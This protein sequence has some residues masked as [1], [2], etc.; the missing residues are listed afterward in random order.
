VYPPNATEDGR[1]WFVALNADSNSASNIHNHS[2]PSEWKI[3]PNVVK[4]IEEVAR[5]NASITPKELQKGTG[6]QYRPMQVSLA[7]NNLHRIRAVVKRVRSDVD[8]IDNEKVNP[9]KIIA[10]FPAVKERVDQTNGTEIA[11]IDRLIGKY[12]LD[13]DDAYSFGRDRQY[14]WF[15]APFQADQWSKADVLFVD[16]DHTGCHHFPYLLNVVCKNEFTQHYMACGRVLINRQDGVSIGNA[17]S[18]LECNVKSLY[19]EYKIGEKHKEILL[20]FDDAEANAFMQAFGADIANI[21]RGCSVHF[22]RS[23]MRVAKLVNLPSSAGYHIFVSIAK[24]IPDERSQKTVIDAFDVLCGIKS[25]ELF[26]IYL[27]PNLKSLKACDVDTSRWKDVQGWVDWWR[28]P[29][30]LRKLSSAFSSLS[31]EEWDDL[32][33]TTN[34][35]ES[36]NRQSVPQNTKS[37][38]LKP[39]IEHFYLEDKR[40]AIMQLAALQNVTISY[41]VAKRKRSRRPPKAPESR[42]LLCVVP[43]GKRAIGTRVSVEFYDD[44][45]GNANK[46]ATKWYRGTIIAYSKQGHTVSFDGYGPEHN[47]TIKSLRKSIESGEVKLL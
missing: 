25:F 7:A 22:L 46:Y 24:R 44:D 30:V 12:Q 6:M 26:S 16:I 43:Q 20:D 23:A 41:Q 35:V 29:N 28:K 27:P 18:K 39:L 31:S 47:E 38:S 8:K 2:L 5:R 3:L 15:Q 42:G 34:P 4:D 40:Q 13:A 1:R 17:L 10:S 45:D 11:G 21:I 9:F 32:P 14:A 37:I 33:G 36:I 19:K